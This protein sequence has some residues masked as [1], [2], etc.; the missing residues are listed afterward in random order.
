MATA[1]IVYATITGNNE[2]IASIIADTLEER[3]LEVSMTEISQADVSDFE[4]ADICIV[5]SYT[6]DEGS[7]P[8]EGLDFFEDLQEA[9]LSGKIYG[10]AGSGDDFYGEY[11]GMAVDKFDQAFAQTKATKGAAN[12]KI[13]LAPD[14]PEDIEKLEN[15]A[16]ELVKSAGI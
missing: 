11:Y 5:C 2:D 9:D 12:V 16:N 4:D 14:S 3:G 8:D 15:F 6:Y 13:N 1:K 7:L 10:V